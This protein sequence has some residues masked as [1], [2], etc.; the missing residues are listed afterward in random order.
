MT[1]SKDKTYSNPIMLNGATDGAYL[2]GKG[3]QSF[4]VGSINEGRLHGNDERIPIENLG[5]FMEYLYA[6]VVDVAGSK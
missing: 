2:R 3:V 6:T 1:T 5:K 4:G